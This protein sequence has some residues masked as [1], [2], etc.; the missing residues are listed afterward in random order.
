MLSR[1][2]VDFGRLQRLSE[3]VDFDRRA[4][5][6]DLGVEAVDVRSDGLRGE[7]RRADAVGVDDFSVI[8]G[9]DARRVELLLE[10]WRGFDGGDFLLLVL[11]LLAAGVQVVSFAANVDG[12]A[13]LN[14]DR[15]RDDVGLGLEP[16]VDDGVVADVVGRVVCV[17]CVIGRWV[18]LLAFSDSRGFDLLDGR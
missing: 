16:A 11:V 5:L 15:R 14:L 17:C 12:F 18:E 2:R 9:H 10:R 4:R 13:L 3:L 7:M 1:C 8:Y 6:E